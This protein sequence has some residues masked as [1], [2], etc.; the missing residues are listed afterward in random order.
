MRKEKRATSVV[1]SCEQLWQ[2]KITAGVVCWPPDDE[3]Q[4]HTP[5]D[6]A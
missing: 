5:V 4:S 1:P 2:K 3:T 6:I